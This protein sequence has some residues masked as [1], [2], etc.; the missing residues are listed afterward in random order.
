MKFVWIPICHNF[1]QRIQ[2]KNV[3]KADYI[4]NDKGEIIGHNVRYYIKKNKVS[5]PYIDGSI[6]IIYGQG[7]FREME[8][9][10]LLKDLMLVELSEN[11]RL[12]FIEDKF[13]GVKEVT[14][15]FLNDA[16]LFKKYIAIV[17]NN[18]YNW[19]DYEV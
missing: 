7:I 14:E 13:R 8:I 11:G 12:I 1:Q 10:T 4:I 3:T 19:S 6:P 15:M 2:L 17:M 9:A 5:P 18:Y 16:T